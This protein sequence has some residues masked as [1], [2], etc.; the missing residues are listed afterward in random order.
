MSR[1]TRSPSNGADTDELPSARVI[2]T[3]SGA[4]VRL[5]SRVEAIEAAVALLERRFRAL[6]RQLLLSN[7]AAVEPHDPISSARRRRGRPLG[8]RNR[9][10]VL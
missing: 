8:S 7:G 2:D 6:D 3:L 9:P 1:T 4:V 10:R 5:F